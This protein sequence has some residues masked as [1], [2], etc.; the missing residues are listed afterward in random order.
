MYII[1]FWRQ[2]LL[3]DTYTE[4]CYKHYKKQKQLIFKKSPTERG[5]NKSAI[6]WLHLKRIIQQRNCNLKLIN[7]EKMVGK[8]SYDE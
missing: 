1:S 7:N 8:E 3:G 5:F 4:K 2:A 6:Y